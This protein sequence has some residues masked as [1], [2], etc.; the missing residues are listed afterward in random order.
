MK[1]QISQS[2]R[3]FFALNR[4]IEFENLLSLEEG[5]MVSQTIDAI[6]LKK[7][8]SQATSPQDLFLKGRDLWRN[9]PQVWNFVSSKKFSQIGSQLLHP[10]LPQRQISLRLGFDQLLEIGKT[11]FPSF[12]PASTLQEV[13]SIQPLLGFILFHFRGEPIDSPPFPKE[14]VNAVFVS[15]HYLMP[16]DLLFQNMLQRFFIIAYCASNS[17]YLF[18]PKD[19]HTHELKR[20]GYGF[21]DH[22]EGKYHPLI[23]KSI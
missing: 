4:F 5:L 3:D 2:H 8:L 21:G 23:F 20:M 18:Q 1:L 11:A 7:R 15:P 22:L 13:T 10:H 16:W 9:S 12:Y 19:L 14:K 17:L 6:L